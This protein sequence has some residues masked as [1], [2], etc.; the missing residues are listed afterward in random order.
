MKK[1]LKVV[2][3]AALSAAMVVPMTATAGE[4][5][6]GADVVSAYVFR[7][8]TINDEVNIQPYV[9][10]AFGSVTAGTWGNYNT[11]ASAFDEIDYY[12]SVDLPLGDD[13]PV[14]VSLG[15]CFYTYPEAV[16]T[17]TAEDGTITGA[18]GVPAD[19]EI[20]LGFSIDAPLSPSLGVNIGVDGGIDELIYLELGFGHEV[21]VTDGVSASAG[22]AIGY[23]ADGPDGTETGFSH[24]TFS[25]GAAY[26]VFSA[27]V[28]FIVETDD[29]VLVVDEDVVGVLSLDLGGALAMLG[30]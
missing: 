7:G 21:E 29:D 1:S 13:V 11:D 4:A 25:L 22:V 8:G 3:G 6:F 19:Q 9:E 14:A 26:S 23:V 24:A 5:S 18:E 30:E 28:N 2:L 15:Y 27:G 16:S 12:A 20:N 10:G 17:T